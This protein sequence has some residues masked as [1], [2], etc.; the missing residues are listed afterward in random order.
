MMDH[1]DDG[2]SWFNDVW[3]W[4][5]MVMGDDELLAYI[6]FLLQEIFFMVAQLRK[7]INGNIT[8]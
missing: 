6:S 1:D 2:M 3:W 7:T 5:I 8:K 4:L